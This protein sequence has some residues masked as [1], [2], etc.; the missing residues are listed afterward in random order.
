MFDSVTDQL[1]KNQGLQKL[2]NYSVIK[3]FHQTTTSQLNFGQ[4]FFC[5]EWEIAFH[6]PIII[7][8]LFFQHLFNRHTLIFSKIKNLNPLLIINN[9]TCEIDV[10]IL[11][12]KFT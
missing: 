9:K 4:H 5:K 10:L 2:Q 3:L 7:S 1:L 8:L 6:H 11:C 12:R